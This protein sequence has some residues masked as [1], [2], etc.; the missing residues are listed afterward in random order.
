LGVVNGEIILK[1]YISCLKTFTARLAHPGT[2]HA[3]AHSRTGMQYQPDQNPSCR[4]VVSEMKCGC[5]W[6]P[7]YK[8]IL[9]TSDSENMQNMSAI[10]S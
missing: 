10:I 9:S 7:L 5:I 8:L 6:H 2:F 4:C 3:H 1:E